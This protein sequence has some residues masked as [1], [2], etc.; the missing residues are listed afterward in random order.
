M[1][2]FKHQSHPNYVADFKKPITIECF[3]II[4]NRKA[5]LQPATYH[6]ALWTHYERETAN[7]AYVIIYNLLLFWLLTI[8]THSP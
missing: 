5:L 4:F 3:V 8:I 1:K 2:I 6:I 7:A